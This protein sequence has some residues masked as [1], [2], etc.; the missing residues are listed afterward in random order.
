MLLRCAECVAALRHSDLTARAGKQRADT[1]I[2]VLDIRSRVAVI[3]KRILKHKVYILYAVVGKIIENYRSYAYIFGYRVKLVIGH[4]GILAMRD[5]ADLFNRLR[6][7]IA[8]KYDVACTRGELCAVYRNR[9]VRDMYQLIVPV[10]PHK[11]YHLEPLCKVERLPRRCY[12]NALVKVIGV[13]S[14]YRRGYIA[15]RI[16]RRAVFFEYQ[17]G[18][19]TVLFKI[20]YLGAVVRLEKSLFA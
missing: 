14:V 11:L 13:F 3:R 1:R 5:L 19:H 17:A 4:F 18:R 7:Q 20:D 9:S 16:Y 8:Q 12:V 10:V 15:R 6:K 2:C